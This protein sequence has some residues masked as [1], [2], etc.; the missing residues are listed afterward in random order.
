VLLAGTFNGWHP[1]ATP[2][3]EDAQGNWSTALTLWPGRYEYKSIIDGKWCCEPG[4]G[5]VEHDCSRCVPN[6]FGTG[7][8]VI[9]VTE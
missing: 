4:C 5:A 3:V 8:H 1:L 2:L 7:N 9:E 6:P